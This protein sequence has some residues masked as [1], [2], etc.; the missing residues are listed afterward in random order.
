MK[1]SDLIVVSI[2]QIQFV[3]ILY[4]M[5]FSFVSFFK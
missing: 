3:V 1:G 2:F 4:S 5:S